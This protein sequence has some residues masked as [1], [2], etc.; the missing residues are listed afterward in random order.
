MTTGL[1]VVDSTCD[2]I[3]K[4]TC[5][6]DNTLAALVLGCGASTSARDL[7]ITGFVPGGS[8]TLGSTWKDKFRASV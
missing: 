3:V 7:E 5:S 8:R 4:D 1:V 6:F 2:L